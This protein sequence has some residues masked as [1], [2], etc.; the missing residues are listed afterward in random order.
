MKTADRIF[1][2]V[3]LVLGCVHCAVAFVVHKSLS[4]EAIWFFSGG[5]AVIFGALLNLLRIARPDDRL[6]ARISALANLLLFAVFAAALPWLVHRELTQNPQ[7]VVVAIAVAAE[8]G[9]SLQQCFR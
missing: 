9:F 1:A 8:F 7:V 4:I 5:L 3:L 6:A 2:W